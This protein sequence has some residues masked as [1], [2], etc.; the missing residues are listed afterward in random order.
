MTLEKMEQLVRD[1]GYELRRRNTRYEFVG[2]DPRPEALREA[3]S[4]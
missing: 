4:E 2:A 1:A 3:V